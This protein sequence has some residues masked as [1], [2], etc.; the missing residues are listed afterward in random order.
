MIVSFR[1]KKV[2]EKSHKNDL[3]RAR[4]TSTDLSGSTLT[5]FVGQ[6][7]TIILHFVGNQQ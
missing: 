4:M 7:P 1:E 5:H 2:S 3:V 6:I